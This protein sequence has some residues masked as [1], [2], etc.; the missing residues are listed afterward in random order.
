M[1]ASKFT[2]FF[3]TIKKWKKKK[4]RFYNSKEKKK[5]TRLLMTPFSSTRKRLEDKKIDVY[6]KYVGR[7]FINISIIK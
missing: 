3:K 1:F 7:T 5:P 6:I 4:F 2:G